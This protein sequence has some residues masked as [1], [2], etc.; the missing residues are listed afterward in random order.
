MSG[1]RGRGRER[2]KHTEGSVHLN[3][4][5]SGVDAR[6]RLVALDS[7]CSEGCLSPWGAGRVVTFLR[8]LF[9]RTR[10]AEVCGGRTRVS[11]E[12]YRRNRIATPKS[13]F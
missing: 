13:G 8:R 11:Y 5:E 9:G 4:P 6:W 12:D 7:G 1:A 2:L 3:A 10:S